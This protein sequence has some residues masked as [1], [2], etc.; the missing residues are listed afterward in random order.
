M[1]NVTT[2]NWPPGS[3]VQFSIEWA[4]IE[5]EEGEVSRAILEHYR[6]VLTTCRDHGLTPVVTPTFGLIAVERATQQR[7]VKPS[8]RWLGTVARTNRPGAGG[9]TDER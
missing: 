8:G 1:G 3:C 9:M 7:T 4:R 5:P 6:R 2:R